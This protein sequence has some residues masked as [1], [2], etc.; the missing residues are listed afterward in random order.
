MTADVVEDVRLLQII[1][2][3]AATDEAGRR[4]SPRREEREKYIVR[5]EPPHRDNVPSGR[6]IQD[7]AEQAEIGNAVGRHTQALQTVEIL[8]ASPAFQK[9]LLALEQETP[10]GVLVLAISVPV[11]LDR[12]VRQPAAHRALQQVLPC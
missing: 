2:L 3:V 6:A 12:M 1:E 10:N 9:L 5:H 7:V 8:T 4:K 11:L